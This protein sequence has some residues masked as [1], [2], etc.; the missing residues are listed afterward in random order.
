MD[1][2]QGLLMLENSVVQ[3]STGKL[4]S[5]IVIPNS[6]LLIG[7][8]ILWR[9]WRN[10]QAQ[11]QAETDE[12]NNEVK[13]IREQMIDNQ[14][15]NESPSN[16]VPTSSEKHTSSVQVGLFEFLIEDNIQLRKHA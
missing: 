6:I 5:A 12:L 16:K 4:V 14:T 2:I 11:L 8:I 10:K 3:I 9:F 15:A 7:G 13:H 1:L